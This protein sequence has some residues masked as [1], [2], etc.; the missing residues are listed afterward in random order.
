MGFFITF[1]GVEGC[2]KT[3][4]ME[5]LRDHLEWKEKAVI[6]VRE[7]GGTMLGEKIRTLLLNSEQWEEGEEL[8]HLSE[9][10]M[11]EACRAQLI[12]NVIKPALDADKIVLCDRY[13]DSTISY[14][15][16]GRGLEK[17]AV[18]WVNEWVSG[19]LVPDLTILIDYPAD[20]GLERA[21]AR[22][23]S[24]AHGNIAHKEDRFEKEDVE[25]HR[26]VRDGYLKLAEA[27]PGRIKV[28][29]GDSDIAAIHKRIC[30]IVKELG[31]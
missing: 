30:E 9:L 25:F 2:G 12:V 21:R 6:A 10:F 13:T 23:E 7:P 1:E 14:Q 3:T 26:R 16:F 8:S 22:I 29:D 15:C 27:E 17:K 24:R 20:K 31:L 4:Q 19:G 11:Y 28:V 5:M 18:D